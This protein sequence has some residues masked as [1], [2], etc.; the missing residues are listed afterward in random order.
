MCNRYISYFEP[1]YLIIFLPTAGIL[2]FVTQN[3]NLKWKTYYILDLF[4][5]MFIPS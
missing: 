1:L 5:T 4:M 3:N 2:I